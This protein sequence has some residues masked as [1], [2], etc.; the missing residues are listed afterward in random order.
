VRWVAE[1]GGTLFGEGVA[2]ADRR[3]DLGAEI[4]ALH[5]ELLDLG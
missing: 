5:G 2:G 1:H 4:A 3:A